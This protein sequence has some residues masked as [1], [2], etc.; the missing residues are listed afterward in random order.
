MTIQ[1]T[2]VP[3]LVSMVKNLIVQ[4]QKSEYTVYSKNRRNN[5]LMKGKACTTV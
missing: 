1:L 5:T 2:L 3:I 4:R